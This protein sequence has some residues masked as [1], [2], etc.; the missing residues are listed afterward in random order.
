MVREKDRQSG[1]TEN[2]TQRY[3]DNRQTV[4]DTDTET[5]RRPKKTEI[6]RQTD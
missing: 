6:H 3:R 5:D 1:K 4:G 2:W